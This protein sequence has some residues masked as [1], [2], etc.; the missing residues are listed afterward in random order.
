[1]N[2]VAYTDGFALDP[3]PTFQNVQFQMRIP[4]PAFQKVRHT[5]IKG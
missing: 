1:M 2:C 5:P 3:D 4:D